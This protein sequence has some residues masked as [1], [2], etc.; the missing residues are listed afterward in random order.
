MAYVQ[1]PTREENELVMG[2][3]A[4]AAGVVDIDRNYSNI[5]C[6]VAPHKS[7]GTVDTSHHASHLLWSSPSGH[8]PICLYQESTACVFIFTPLTL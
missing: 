1:P 3:K 4:Q 2:Q 8:N 6:S 5:K 7:L